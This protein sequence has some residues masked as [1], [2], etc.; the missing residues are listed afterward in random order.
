[1]TKPCWHMSPSGIRHPCLCLCISIP[2]R[3]LPRAT[4][5]EPLSNHHVPGMQI[6]EDVARTSLDSNLLK[7]S[8]KGYL[9]NAGLCQLARQPPARPSPRFPFQLCF[10]NDFCISRIGRAP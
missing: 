10:S 7:Y 4:C 6:F 2:L 9:L 1:M 3:R 5:S 8:A